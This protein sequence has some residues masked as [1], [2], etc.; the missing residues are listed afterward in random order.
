MNY[1]INDNIKRLER[2]KSKEDRSS[3]LRLD[4][5]ENPK[6]LPEDFVKYVLSQINS[7]FISMYPQKDGLIQL[8]AEENNINTENI[9]I[10]NGS[11]EAIRLI[12][13][14]FGENNKNIITVSPSFEMYDVYSKMFGINNIKIP[15]NESLNID[16]DTIVNSIDNNTRVVVV[17]NPN[18]PIGNAF[19]ENDM[20]EIVNKAQKCN[21]IVVIDEAYYGF[22]EN[23]FEKFVKKYDNV[24]CLRTFS[25][26]YSI[27]GL[28]IGYI[29]G[30]KELIQYIENAEATYNVNS[31]AILFAEEILKNKELKNKLIESEKIGHEYV[32]E[33][34]KKNNYQV[35]SL[36]GNYVLFK[37][38]LSPYK[39]ATRLKEKGI[40]VKTYSRGIL[41]KYIRI[42]TGDIEIMEK[43]IKEL[44]IVDL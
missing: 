9:S 24:L 15:Y 2:I 22:C 28:R 29:I 18:S 7:E 10:T 30:A 35:Y 8:L 13:E 1:Y 6:G 33:Q 31:V 41:E 17:L 26:L 25:K 37:S 36:S 3:Y 19:S 34:L 39:V 43:F 11:D 38:K 16:V 23:T 20:I 5:N 32:V 44:V 27:A 14:T 40:L 4:M 21:S 12:L 42:T